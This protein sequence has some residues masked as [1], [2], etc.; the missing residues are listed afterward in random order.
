MASTVKLTPEQE[1]QLRVQIAALQDL[2]GSIDALDE[3]GLECQERRVKAQSLMR[4]MQKTLE[5][6]GGGM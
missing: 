5:R 3:C 2:L 1:D 4:R 6:F